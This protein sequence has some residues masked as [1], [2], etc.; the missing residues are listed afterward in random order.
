MSWT[1]V[2]KA[3][4]GTVAAAVVDGE[5]PNG[6]FVITGHD[7]ESVTHL[8]VTRRTELGH[9]LI[10]AANAEPRDDASG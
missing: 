1:I 5:V 4:A 7:E 8:E 6:E 10:T 3:N 9:H 2:V